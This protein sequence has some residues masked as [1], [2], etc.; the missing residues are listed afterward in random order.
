MS[1]TNTKETLHVSIANSNVNWAISP[2]ADNLSENL[3]S[4][5][6]D[7]HPYVPLDTII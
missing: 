3:V 7:I 6:Q 1:D 5:G 4:E 2:F